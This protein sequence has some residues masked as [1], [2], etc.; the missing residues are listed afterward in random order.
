MPLVVAAAAVWISAVWAI[1][2]HAVTLAH[3]AGHA[4]VAIATGRRLSGI[5]LHSDTS[6]LTV[7]KGKPRGPGMVLTCAAGYLAPS[8]LGLAGA[9]LVANDQLRVLIWGA[10]VAVVA[11]LPFIRNFFG[12]LVLVAVAAV[13]AGVAHYGSADVQLQFGYVVIWLLLIGNVRTIVEAARNR[14]G[15]SDFDQLRA[16]TRVPRAVWIVLLFALSVATGV[17]AWR[18]Q[19]VG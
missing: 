13:F 11:M 8:L 3:E 10:V 5:R 14:S 2:R 7:S 18:V 16:L 19:Y 4:V 6:G 15:R 1:T 9:L 12:L 17:L